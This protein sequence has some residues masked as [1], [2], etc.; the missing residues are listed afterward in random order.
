MWSALAVSAALRGS[1]RPWVRGQRTLAV[2]WSW[3]LLFSG[4]FLW[5]FPLASWLA[6]GLRW[7]GFILGCPPSVASLWRVLT[8]FFVRYLLACLHDAAVPLGYWVRWCS[9]SSCWVIYLMSVRCSSSVHDRD[10]ALPP[11]VGLAFHLCAVLLPQADS[12]G[13]GLC[14]S[15]RLSDLLTGRC[16]SFALDSSSLA[17]LKGE[18]STVFLLLCLPSGCG[19]F[20]WLLFGVIIV[21]CH[22]GSPT[23][24]SIG[25]FF[26]LCGSLPFSC[27]VIVSL[28]PLSVCL[29]S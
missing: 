15:A 7:L 6:A 28:H 11:L 20:L 8:W 26:L 17:W 13:F 16:C 1:S 10:V 2:G 19:D 18:L 12:V 23:K 5:F 27:A 25:G 22:Y 29:G 14:W 21:F 24:V 9:Y 4:T 3:Y